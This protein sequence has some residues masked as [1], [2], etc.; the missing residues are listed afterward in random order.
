MQRA[1]LRYHAGAE[2]TEDH[3]A[4]HAAED[5][6]I[7]DP[8]ALADRPRRPGQHHAAG[9]Q[10]TEGDAEQLGPAKALPETQVGH[11]RH[12]RRIAR[13]DQ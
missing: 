5:R 7:T 2:H 11:D 4:Q 8:V 6:R 13:N 9:A 3:P 12:D 10:Q 1:D